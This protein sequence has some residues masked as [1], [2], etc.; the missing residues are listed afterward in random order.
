M[1]VEE[2]VLLAYARL[3]TPTLARTR[4][5]ITAIDE[6]VRCGGVWVRAG[7]II[8]VADGSGVICVPAEHSAQ[9]TE[10][11]S[12]DARQDEL[13]AAKLARGLSFRQAMAKFTRI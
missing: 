10:L 13:A 12:Q 2:E 7:D 11:A 1:R 8:I 6:P 9:V 4:L 3:A 5:A